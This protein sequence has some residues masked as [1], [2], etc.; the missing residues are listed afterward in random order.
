MPRFDLQCLAGLDYADRPVTDL[1]RL[2]PLDGVRSPMHSV[3]LALEHPVFHFMA[4]TMTPMLQSP[5][6]SVERMAADDTCLRIRT[7]AVR[8]HRSPLRWAAYRR[9]L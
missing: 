2:L 1:W 5:N 6:F 3:P 8:R 7:L 4:H 9:L